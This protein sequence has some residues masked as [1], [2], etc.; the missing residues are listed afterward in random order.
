MKPGDELMGGGESKRVTRAKK[1]EQ[2]RGMGYNIHV[3]R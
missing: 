3:S 1:R 2:P